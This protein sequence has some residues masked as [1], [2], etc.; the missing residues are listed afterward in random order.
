MTKW[1]LQIDPVF[2]TTNSYKIQKHFIELIT[3]FAKYII[4]IRK[5]KMR[6][7][8]N[9]VWEK[10]SEENIEETSH[11]SAVDRFLLSDQLNVEELIHEI[12][13]LFTS[14]CIIVYK[15]S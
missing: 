1:Y 15:I 4:D 7:I 10:N 12:F 13:T 9:Y 14:V 8:K 11:L 3:D 2:R 5:S 6:V